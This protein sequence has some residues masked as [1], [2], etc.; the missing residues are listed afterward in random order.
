MSRMGSTRRCARQAASGPRPAVVDP[1][2]AAG[3]G[4]PEARR[5]ALHGH[6]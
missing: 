6:G 1:A 3:I 2:S 5:V 4:A